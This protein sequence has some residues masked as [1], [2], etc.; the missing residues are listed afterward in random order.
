M[1]AF[2]Q[3]RYRCDDKVLTV[4]ADMLE[5]ERTRIYQH[6][7]KLP[8]GTTFVK[9]GT[10]PSGP[11]K[12]KVSLLQSVQAWELREDL[13]KRLHFFFSMAGKKDHPSGT[14]SGWEGG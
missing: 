14:C 8:P 4:P 1:P 2:A 13:K 7:I 3:G 9:E 5:Q 12:T 6:K 10:R 11:N